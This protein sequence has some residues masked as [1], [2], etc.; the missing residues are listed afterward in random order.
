MKLHK[1]LG[2]IVYEEMYFEEINLKFLIHRNL[3]SENTR[4]MIMN[5]LV[6]GEVPSNINV[7]I[8]YDICCFEPIDGDDNLYMEEN[9]NYLWFAL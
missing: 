4:D 1:F 3:I 5:Y 6:S 7:K 8:A 2:S 9:E